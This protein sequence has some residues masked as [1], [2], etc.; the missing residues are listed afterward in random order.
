MVTKRGFAALNRPSIKSAL[1]I[2]E[3]VPLFVCLFVVVVVVVV[4]V[5]FGENHPRI[6]REESVITKGLKQRQI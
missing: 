4:V 5:V 2:T 3:L 1:V 6:H